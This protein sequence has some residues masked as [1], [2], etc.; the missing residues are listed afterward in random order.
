MKVMDV[1][2]D[3]A[4]Y[5]NKDKFVKALLYLK[6][7][8]PSIDKVPAGFDVPKP[9]NR[10]DDFVLMQF[11]AFNNSSL[12]YAH[13]AP[14]FLPWHR[15]YLRLFEK[16]LQKN[17]QF[18]DVTI[19]Y[20][21]W[22]SEASTRALFSDEVM[23]N[24]GRYSDGRVMRGQFA[25]DKGNWTLY[26]DTRFDLGSGFNR[27]D[28]C[29]KLGYRQLD[30]RVGR[31]V[32]P[33]SEDIDG[34]L[35][36]E[37]Y[38]AEPWNSSQFAKPSFRNHLEGNYPGNVRPHNSVHMWVGGIREQTIENQQREVL[39]IG[40]MAGASSPNDPIFFLHHSN[41][42]RLWADWQLQANHWSLPYKGYL[43]INSEQLESQPYSVNEPLKPW[44]IYTP[45]STADFYQIDSQGYKYD[46]Y[47]RKEIVD[48][49][50]TPCIQNK[51][52]DLNIHLDVSSSSSLEAFSM[53]NS[54][55]E[56]QFKLIFGN[57]DNF[58]ASVNKSFFALDPLD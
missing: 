45:A 15:V 7:E 49:K 21:D 57:P 40:T 9:T 26:H 48:Q 56:N 35:A 53:E 34:V 14:T 44:N 38:D 5:K 36:T 12:M 47:H 25:Y 37:P 6:N 19:P 46:R 27:P 22:T 32:L 52:V 41:I 8:A 58:R 16:E 17:P 1:R 11:L 50:S 51:S 33:T 23:G 54:F 43:P 42:D 24:D 13:G 55:D 39:Y 3:I 29:R 30:D 31:I 10:Y 20:W 4:N 18:S 28:L 2:F